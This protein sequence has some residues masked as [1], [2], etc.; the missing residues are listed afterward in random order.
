MNKYAIKEIVAVLLR[1][2]RWQISLTSNITKAFLQICVRREDRDVHRFLWKHD[3]R[4][5]TIRFTRVP[6]GNKNSPFLINATI[7]HHLNLCPQSEVLEE[8][9]EN[10]NY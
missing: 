10:T 8:L 6:F 4:V 2:R 5:R 7:K 1:F 9:K 3:D